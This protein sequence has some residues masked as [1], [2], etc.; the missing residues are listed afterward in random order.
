MVLTIATLTT[1]YGWVPRQANCLLGP[2]REPL[3]RFRVSIVPSWDRLGVVWGGLGGSLG[4]LGG[5]LGRLGAF[6]CHAPCL[7]LPC[8]LAPGVYSAVLLV[9]FYP[10]PPLLGRIFCRDP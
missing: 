7:C 1:A 3:G 5:L 2:S 10:A 9:L 8:S 4:C 6:F